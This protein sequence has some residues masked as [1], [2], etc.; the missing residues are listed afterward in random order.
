M[1][2]TSLDASIGTGFQDN[3][4]THLAVRNQLSPLLSAGL[5]VQTGLPK[6]RFVGTKVM[7]EGYTFSASAPLALMLADEDRA[8][9]YGIGRIGMR[10]QGIIDPDGNDMRDSIL[11]STAVLGEL[12]FLAGLS[13]SEG[14]NFQGGISFPLAYEINPLALMEYAW[15]KLHLGG[16]L[17]L[18]NATLFAHTNIGHAFGATGDTYKSI[19]STEAGIRFNLGEL[20]NDR[21]KL[22]QPS[23]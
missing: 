12:G 2:Q 9:L 10:W 18:G 21:F 7:R 5:E 20:K 4:S 23:F 1:A 15:V 16:S 22:I 8:Q 17:N 11:Q 19:W 6:Y 14:L 3:F 13:A